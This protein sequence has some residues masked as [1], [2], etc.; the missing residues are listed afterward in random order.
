MY[1]VKG[2]SFN[3]GYLFHRSVTSVSTTPHIIAQLD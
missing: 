2:H 3:Q 1:L